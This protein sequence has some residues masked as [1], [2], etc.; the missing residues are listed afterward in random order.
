MI[1]DLNLS[2][3]FAS[4]ILVPAITSIQSL[5]IILKQVELFSNVEDYR[6]CF[7]LIQQTRMDEEGRFHIGIKR[8][9]NII[10]MARGDADPAAK[11]VTSLQFE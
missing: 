1:Q 8:L 2:E 5:D 9:L 7:Q 4:E 6:R 3:V 11:L 10:E